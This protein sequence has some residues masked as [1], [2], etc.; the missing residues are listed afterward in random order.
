MR[1]TL[2]RF[3][4]WLAR[5]P[6][7]DDL[8]RQH[9]VVLQLFALVAALA[10][11]GLEAARL[12]GGASP[13]LRPATLSN[14]TSSAL[15]LFALAA[16]RRGRLRLGS[17]ILAG[18][19][20]VVL[21]TATAFAGLTF[22]RDAVRNLALPLSLVALVLGR[23]ALWASLLAATGFLAVAWARD[24][25]LLGG[26]GP[27]HSPA[28]PTSIFASSVAVLALLGIV[29]DRFGLTVAEAFSGAVV[30]Q[31]E[32]EATAAELTRANAA[33]AAEME[34]RRAAQA[35]LVRSQKL[36]AIAR[37]SGG[38]AHDFNNV[39]TAIVGFA[40]MARAD[41]P[42]GSQARRDMEE[43]VAVARR[44]GALTRQL[45][46]FARRQVV[47]PVVLRVD[48]HVR[49][50]EAM[51]RRLLRTDIELVSRGASD[52]WPVR[53]DQGQL[54]QVLVN[55]AVNAR[56]AMP[57]GGR[58]TIETANLTVEAPR[59]LARGTLA[60]GDW[61]RL[62][63]T[64]TG[65]GMDEETRR[66]LFEPFFTTKE[67]GQG[68]GLGLA[69]CWGIVE[70]AG[71]A[72]DVASAPGRGTTFDVYLPR[73]TGEAAVA[74]PEAAPAPRGR[75]ETLLLIEDDEG[76]RRILARTLG[77]LGYEVLA[78]GDGDQAV[79]AAAARAG[80]LHLV[81]ADVV[82][83]GASGRDAALGIAR[84]RPETRVLLTS[85]HPERGEP[86]PGE[87]GVHFL[88]KPYSPAALAHRVRA[89]LDAGDGSQP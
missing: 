11:L 31:R 48:A 60:P 52:L 86:A 75:G 17:W 68:T 73:A 42:A 34:A 35:Q 23:R 56:D 53:I 18:G 59:T 76:L 12:I 69:T 58:L 49:S 36:E 4:E 14:L 8:E 50:T 84:G 77:A 65:A 37:L 45:L 40:D 57:D 61:V 51:L 2:D 72:I 47:E 66:R 21:G 32:L 63:V 7:A 41:L 9:A 15:N 39:L 71:G 28:S 16:V 67:V 3:Q 85:G 38:V 55:L 87:G 80:P 33:L 10:M 13:A 1:G 29:L 88:A 81:I 27:S 44:G 54:E 22:A 82:L 89:I 19:N 6:V 70:Q 83:P 20:L 74:D 5:V 26:L 78:A 62:S 24:L 43:I 30:R 64:D 25:H 79:R 46:A